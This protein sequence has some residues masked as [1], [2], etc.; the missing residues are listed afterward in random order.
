MD[1][2]ENDNMEPCRI[3]ARALICGTC[4]HVRGKNLRLILNTHIYIYIYRYVFTQGFAI[5][6]LWNDDSLISGHFESL[7]SFLHVK[8]VGLIWTST[9]CHFWHHDCWPHLTLAGAWRFA[10][11][12]WLWPSMEAPLRLK[13]SEKGMGRWNSGNENIYSRRKQHEP[14]G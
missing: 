3:F 8:K 13:K 12:L 4:H 7:P 14:R 2:L 6:C 1:I 9:S 5:A 10:A 11:R